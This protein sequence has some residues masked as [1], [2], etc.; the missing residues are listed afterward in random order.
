M[1]EA[2]IYAHIPKLVERSRPQAVP[3][4]VLTLVARA[5]ARGIVVLVRERWDG[6]VVVGWLH[7]A[8]LLKLET[9]RLFAQVEKS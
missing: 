3:A 4:V 9:L 8:C 7:E 2:D 1:R 5:R 6:W